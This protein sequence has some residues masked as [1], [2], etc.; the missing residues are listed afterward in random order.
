LI[1]LTISCG[2]FQQVSQQLIFK[3]FLPSYNEKSNG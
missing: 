1:F 2:I 3:P